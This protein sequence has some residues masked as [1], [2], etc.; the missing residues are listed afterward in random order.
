MADF[1]FHEWLP[2]R[3]SFDTLDDTD[4]SFWGAPVSEEIASFLSIRQSALN[5]IDVVCDR[6]PRHSDPWDETDA[7]HVPAWTVEAISPPGY[8]MPLVQFVEYRGSNTV[9]LYL[10]ADLPSN[11]S[12]HVTATG[13]V[14]LDDVPF[15]GCG[16]G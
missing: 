15:G 13:L 11:G 16:D 7:L 6:E 1:A 14:A 12:I 8:A 2:V 9:R 5:A 3:S 10:D 4:A